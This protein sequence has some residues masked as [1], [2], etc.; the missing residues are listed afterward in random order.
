MGSALI[1]NPADTAH[2]GDDYLFAQLAPEQPTDTCEIVA[3]LR[4]IK[5]LDPLSQDEVVWL[6]EHGTERKAHDG[7]L[8]FHGGTP[9]HHMTILLRGEI[10]VRRNAGPLS[11]FIG[12][13]GLVT[14]KLPFSR[15][16]NYGGDGY[17]VGD[18]WTLDFDESTFP[19]VLA[20]VPSLTQI[21]V[22]TLLDR[23]REVTRM[24]QQAEK[25]N[26]LGKLAANLSHELNNPASAARSAANNLWTEL[27]HYGDQKFKLGSLC[28]TTETKQAYGQWIQSVRDLLTPDGRP[29]RADAFEVSSREDMLM[30]WLKSK[31]IEEGWRIAPVLAET[32]IDVPQLER[33]A[34]IMSGEALT[35]SLGA[36]ASA[37]QAE[38]MT[39]AVIDSTR[40][41]FELISAIKDY[42]YMDQGPIQEVDLGQALD[43]TMTM[44]NSRLASVEVRR[45]YAV[46][47]PQ[48]S[49]YGG[50]LN[51]VWTALL[52]NAL[53]AMA[54]C[55]D[56]QKAVLTLRTCLS[57]STVL[58]EVCDNGPG[59]PEEIR[60]RIFEPFFTTK[61]VG[62]ALG[63]GLDTANRLVTKHKGQLSVLSKP[64]ET[65]IQV[66]LPI[67]Q[68][69][70][71]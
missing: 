22:S 21:V 23:T 7:T 2:E 38:R 67:E 51:Q 37:L 3:A 69:G 56:K 60:S 34:G 66:R 50:E 19:E 54:L 27:R 68:T 39:D 64:G 30:D 59:I 36:F 11:F 71:Y 61:A 14:G 55:A 15:M 5:T 32:R 10:H 35:V 28:F 41:I 47:V 6:A 1:T 40:R 57:G 18:V 52:E 53:D 44:L 63:L 48:I 70:A 31:G 26:A 24:E 20:A 25:L 58:V 45:E 46:D 33:L 62:Q 49:A 42:S 13:S 4:R 12:R 8:I 17:A 9:V 29:H 43:N 65:C 16:K